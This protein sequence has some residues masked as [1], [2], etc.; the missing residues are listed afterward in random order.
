[1]PVTE[2]EI[3]LKLTTKLG[4]AGNSQ[5]GTPAGSLG[6]YISTTQFVSDNLHNIFD[7]VS[8][9]ENLAM[10][11]EYRCLAYHN[12]N[13][14]LD[15]TVAKVFIQ[16]EAAGGASIAIGVDPNAASPIGQVA[17]QFAEI[18]NED[19]APAGV[20]FTSPVDYANGVLLGT[21]A[22]GTCRGLWVRR[23]TTNSPAMANDT[24]T[25]RI[26]GE[27]VG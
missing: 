4:A 10:E 25:L 7:A 20:V 2:A 24:A 9:A 6:K 1:M 21:L 17:A 5:A 22:P 23:L 27:T 14:A 26:Q 11:F 16:A 19:T 3:L 15:L 13:G 18:A 8:A 12:S